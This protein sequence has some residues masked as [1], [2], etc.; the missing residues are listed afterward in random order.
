MDLTMDKR[1]SLGVHVS[2]LRLPLKQALHTVANLGADAVEI[3]ARST[4][5]PEELTQTGARHL[6]KMLEDLNLRTAALTFVTQ[7]G[8]HDEEE[9][10][11]RIQAAQR[12]LQTAYRLGARW[13]VTNLG[14]IPGEEDQSRWNLLREVLLDL[15]RY[16]HHVGAML[17]AET[18]QDDGTVLAR[19]VESLPEGTLWVAFNP[20]RLLMHGFNAR[21]ALERLAR[22]VQYV[23][24]TDAVRDPHRGSGL[25]VPLGRGVADFPAI[26]GTLEEFQYRGYITVLCE[27]ATDPVSEVR[28][29]LEYLRNVAQ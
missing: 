24:A 28:T 5:R 10:E 7:R 2:S 29:A 9:L 3:D 20:G 15:G 23:Y 4:L 18:G 13:V 12:T 17:A 8:F 1:F 16:G 14:N 26:L 22:H 11:R 27:N 21:T 19:L 6:R 25:A